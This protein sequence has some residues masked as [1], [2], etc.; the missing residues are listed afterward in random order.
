MPKETRLQDILNILDEHSPMTAEQ[1]SQNL[2]TSLPTI[3]R[4][5]RELSRRKLIVHNR[6]LVQRAQPQTVTT[7]LDFRRAIQAKEKAAI[8]KAAAGL[9]QPGSTVFIDAST[10]A[11][12]LIPE[13]EGQE[14][15]TVLTNGLVTAMLLKRAGIRT[16]CLG[17]GL[18]ENSLAVSG[19]STIELVRRFRID[20][21]LFSAYGIS[22]SGMIVDPSEGELSL[23]R[24]ILRHTGVSVLLCDRSKFGKTSLFNM[25]PLTAV[26]YLVTDARPTPEEAPVRQQVI[27]VPVP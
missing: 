21:M 9:I 13:L 8:A 16:Y 14:D 17:G 1:L 22:P 26:D 6:G 18:V 5:L 4:D 10:T 27:T 3:Y 25:A 7:P 15:I 20:T 12:Y 19:Q 23:R 2:F 24:Y 11:S